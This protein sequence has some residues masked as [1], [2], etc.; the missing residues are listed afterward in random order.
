MFCEDVSKLIWESWMGRG[1]LVSAGELIT[2]IN[3]PLREGKAF[4]P[5]TGRRRAYI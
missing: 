3:F 5:G 2:G 1:E 4:N